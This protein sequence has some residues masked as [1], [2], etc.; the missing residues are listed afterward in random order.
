MS[1]HFFSITFDYHLQ[2]STQFSKTH[3][4]DLLF[5]FITPRHGRRRKHSL[6]VVEKACLLIRCLAMDILLLRVYTSAVMCLPSLCIA[7]GIYVTLYNIQEPIMRK[8]RIK[9]CEIYHRF[10]EWK[11]SIVLPQKQSSRGS[12]DGYI[13]Q[14][15]A[16][17][18]TRYTAECVR[19]IRPNWCKLLQ[20]C[21][22]WIDGSFQHICC[23]EIKREGCGR[24]CSWP[25]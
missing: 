2:N 20:H 15:S 13:H 5:P 4:N 3:S 18:E 6:S 9:K 10:L 25:R 1:C 16:C 7:M 11:R 24:Q 8:P 17:M 12:S 14:A 23:I 21:A 22:H 19:D